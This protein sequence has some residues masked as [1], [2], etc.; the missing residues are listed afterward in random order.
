MVFMI[1]NLNRPIVL[2]SHMGKIVSHVRGTKYDWESTENSGGRTG[3]IIQ[4]RFHTG[5]K[6]D[7]ICVS[8]E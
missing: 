2:P 7:G 1:M 5:K 8:D 3:Q 6:N 4:P